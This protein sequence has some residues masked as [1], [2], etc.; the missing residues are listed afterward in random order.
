MKS[1]VKVT[2]KDSRGNIKQVVEGHNF[3]T[4]SFLEAVASQGFRG[5]LGESNMGMSTGG[6]L[7]PTNGLIQ[8]L[9]LSDNTVAQDRSIK[10]FPGNLKGITCGFSPI[11]TTP[12]SRLGYFE[13]IKNTVNG[14]K[15]KAV[16]DEGVEGVIG[17]IGFVLPQD[18]NYN[19]SRSLELYK[20]PW[21]E[22]LTAI[23]KTPSYTESENILGETSGYFRG[24][25]A[26]NEEDIYMIY[27]SQTEIFVFKLVD[28]ELKYV[29]SFFSGDWNNLSNNQ[30]AVW[31]DS[32]NRY[33]T[34]IRCTDGGAYRGVF[35]DDMLSLEEE[36]ISK[37]SFLNHGKI[38]EDDDYIYNYAF[39]SHDPLDSQ[40]DSRASVRRYVKGSTSSPAEKTI[41][42]SDSDVDK[43]MIFCSQQYEGSKVLTP[44][45][46]IFDFAE[47]WNTDNWS[48]STSTQ[49]FP[50][51]PNLLCYP[52]RVG[53]TYYGAFARDSILSKV[54]GYPFDQIPLGQTQYTS[55]MNDDI[56][57]KSDSIT[58]CMT[59]LVLASP[60]NKLVTDSLIIE[61][62]L[63]YN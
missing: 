45:G 32:S 16:F 57:V 19:L 29:S 42:I 31:K 10:K 9:A 3:I 44:N 13:S 15:A 17:T 43:Y 35:S 5:I 6:R 38:V 50:D 59:C 39:K 11:Q 56:F 24:V 48:L 53:N 26:K 30:R 46:Y 52:T 2:L 58:N 27:G 51:M 36:Y 49:A 20:G 18:L 41:N 55:G 14:I 23:G 1:N 8:A 25:I 22:S 63:C 37:S 33:C 28:N 61:Y 4:N 47:A 7:L 54:Q 40:G 34:S 21:G 12:A 62:T 60:I